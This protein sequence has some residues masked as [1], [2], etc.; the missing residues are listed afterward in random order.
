MSLIIGIDPG[1]SGGIAIIPMYAFH[2]TIAY[3]LAR[4]TLS[5]ISNLLHD[6][7]HGISE[8]YEDTSVEIFIEQPSL[9]PYLPGGGTRNA[10][11][12][13]KLGRSLGQ[14][15]GVVYS[16]GY[17][18]TMISPQKWQTTLGCRTG[19]DKRVTHTLANSIFPFMKKTTKKGTEKS[20]VTHGVADALLIALYGYLLHVDPKYIPNCVRNNISLAGERNPKEKKNVHSSNHERVVPRRSASSR[21]RPSIATRSDRRMPP[22][23]RS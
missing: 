18:P 7:R 4:Y 20:L 8:F 10:Q 3:P 21:S 23:K 6:T 13:W 5:D 2:K 9:N 14:L 16:H 11:S 22:R 12:F 1:V 19:G 17:K 15:E